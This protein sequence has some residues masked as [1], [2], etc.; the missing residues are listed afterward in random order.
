MNSENDSES[1][2]EQPTTVQK[3]RQYKG[4][5]SQCGYFDESIALVKE[6]KDNFW[7]CYMSGD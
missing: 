7:I 1:D 6:T 5:N 4:I 3:P 2:V